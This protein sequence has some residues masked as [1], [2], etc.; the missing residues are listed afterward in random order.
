MEVKIKPID[1]RNWESIQ[2][3]L[4]RPFTDEEVYWRLDRGNSI[5]CYVDARSIMERLDKTVGSEN[6]QCTYL[7]MPSGRVICKLG[8]RINKEWIW[9]EDGA[10]NPSMHGQNAESHAAKGG[11]SNAL[12]RAAVVWGLAR[13]LYDLGDTKVQMSTK[14]PADAPKCRIVKIKGQYGVA[15]SLRDIQFHL[16]SYDE[17]VR[18]IKDPRERRIERLRCVGRRENLPNDER[19]AIF[20]A[21]SAKWMKGTPVEPGVDH[22]NKASDALLGVASQRLAEWSEKGVINGMMKAYAEW[23][24]QGGGS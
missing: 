9:K 16:Y 10:G 7:E 4:T 20:E 24:V 22:P 3:E 14:Y 19:K 5:L 21:A 23:R 1:G 17:L 2:R 11:L 12:K 13:H 6:W 18:H 15:P 8:I